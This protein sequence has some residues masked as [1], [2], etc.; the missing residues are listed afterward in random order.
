MLSSC[1]RSSADAAVESIV[2]AKN[3]D[4]IV[5]LVI[6]NPPLF[7]GS[8]NNKR[9]RERAPVLDAG[10]TDNSRAPEHHRLRLKSPASAEIRATSFLPRRIS[11][12][13]SKAQRLSSVPRLTQERQLPAGAAGT[14]L[15]CYPAAY[16]AYGPYRPPA[17][18]CLSLGPTGSSTAL[19]RSFCQDTNIGRRCR[20]RV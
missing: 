3:R 16:G 7:N 1:K 4:V 2:D 8:S 19:N 9:P 5:C 13:R 17:I 14:V 10:P 18:A 15:I 20:C 11:S 6:K 12:C